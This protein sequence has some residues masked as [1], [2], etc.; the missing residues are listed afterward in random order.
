MQVSYES[1]NT[2]PVRACIIFNPVARG[3]KA[4]RFREQIAAFSQQCVL[5]P[6]LGPGGGRVLAAEAV[7]EGFDTVVAAGGDGTL[8]EVLNGIADEPDGLVRT[9]LGILPLGTVNVFAREL[10]LPMNVLQAWQILLAGH[11]RKVDLGL[12]RFTDAGQPVCRYFAQ[13]A[14]AGMDARAIELVDWKHKKQIG[15]L[16]YVISAAKAIQGHLPQ[17]AVSNRTEAFG[18]ELVLIGNGRFYGGKFV[19]FP[20]ASLCDGILEVTVFPRVKWSVVARCGW[21]V[22]N[23][24]PPAAGLALQLR[25]NTIELNCPTPVPFHL[26]GENSGRLPATFTI[27]TDALRIIAP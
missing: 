10:G 2:G 26:D 24:R 20:L 27:H 7:R 11:E 12:A 16:A 14:G 25:G 23:G 1:L 13:M 22:M 9:R 21:N 3:D 17:I 19:L 6:T 4:R 8:N 15:P 18:G 5:K